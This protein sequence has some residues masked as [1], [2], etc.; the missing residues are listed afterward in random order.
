MTGIIQLEHQGDIDFIGA[1]LAVLAAGAVDQAQLIEGLAYLL[2][3]G[4]FFC[5]SA[6]NT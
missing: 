4:L 2:D 1:G 5:S 3:H 6:A